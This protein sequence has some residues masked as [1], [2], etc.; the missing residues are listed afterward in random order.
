[1]SKKRRSRGRRSVIGRFDF[2]FNPLTIE[3][4]PDEVMA[5]LMFHGDGAV[6]EEPPA[7]NGRRIEGRAA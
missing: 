3:L 1:M 6:D 4:S 7:D 2:D 5:D